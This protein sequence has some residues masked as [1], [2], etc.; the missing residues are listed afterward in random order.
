MNAAA[1]R[2]GHVS[3]EGGP[4]LIGDRE[5]ARSWR[6]AFG[7]GAD[8]KRAC[9]RLETNAAVP[10]VQI[11][12]SG[13]AA[14]VWDMPTGTAEVWRRGADSLILSR[15]WFAVDADIDRVGYQLASLPAQH[16]V[17]LGSFE[18]DDG[19]LLIVWAAEDGTHIVNVAPTDGLALDLSVGHAGLIATLPAGR[20]ACYH[21]EVSDGSSNSRRCLI[22]ADRTL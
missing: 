1:K 2:I 21:D 13:M 8:Y 14:I 17:R 19:W 16:L 11:E 18:L 22:V 3:T 12:V 6:G 4:L 15:P 10:G 20:Y 7:D 5:L 9:E